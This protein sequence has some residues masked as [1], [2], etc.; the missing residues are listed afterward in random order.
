MS[1]NN[2]RY[3]SKNEE[4]NQEVCD[5]ILTKSYGETIPFEILCKMLGYN[6]DSEEET[7]KFKSRMCKIKNILIDYGYVLKSISNVGYYILKPKQISGYCYRTYIDKTKRLLEK[8]EIILHN[9]DTKE[10]TDVRKKEHTE[11]KTL[12]RDVYN[13]VGY[14]VTNSDYN[15]NKDYYNSLND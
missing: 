14:V 11:M 15:K 4:V 5:F 2:Y 13:K 6:Y 12:N 10:L 7:K 8:S 9:V 3:N 1:Y